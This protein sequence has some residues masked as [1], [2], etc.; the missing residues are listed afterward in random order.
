MIRSLIEMFV[1]HPSLT[2][3]SS[4]ASLNLTVSLSTFIYL[5]FFLH[6][7]LILNANIIQ[8]YGRFSTIA[9][10]LTRNLVLVLSCTAKSFPVNNRYAYQSLS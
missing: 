7:S 5:I 4:V 10:L 1:S 2:N 9:P 8:L 6:I 3:S